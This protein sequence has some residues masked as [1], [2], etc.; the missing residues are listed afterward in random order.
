MPEWFLQK[1]FREQVLLTIGF[2]A[3]F[4]YILLE[5]I[6]FPLLQSKQLARENY[7]HQLASLQLLKQAQPYLTQS[8]DSSTSHYTPID[9]TVLL[10]TLDTMLN[11][12]ELK[13]YVTQFNQQADNQVS[14]QFTHVPFDN[15]LQFIIQV[16]QKHHIAII[17][18]SA[19]PTSP[20]G[21]AMV[22]LKFAV[23]NR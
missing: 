5:L 12:A 6:I 3:I 9:S 22:S 19:T 14:I 20:T 15:L 8:H 17:E 16:W 11:K 13:I 18:F 23:K 21:T 10:S 7:V 1:T 2:S 4:I